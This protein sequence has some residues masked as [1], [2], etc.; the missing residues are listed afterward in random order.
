VG[1]QSAMGIG[2]RNF[3]IDPS[4]NFVLVANQK[5]NNIIIFSRNKF[6]GLLKDTGKKIEIPSPVCLKMLKHSFQ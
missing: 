2:P 1:Y 6:T 5:T 3:M 4:G